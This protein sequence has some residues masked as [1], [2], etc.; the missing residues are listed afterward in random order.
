ALNVHSDDPLLH[1]YSSTQEKLEAITEQ[2]NKAKLKIQALE[3]DIE[4]L[5]GEFELDRL[6]YLETIRKQDQQVKLLQ[7]ILDKVLIMLKF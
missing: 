5:H 3:N 2:Y 1:V 6:D 4:D 7:Q